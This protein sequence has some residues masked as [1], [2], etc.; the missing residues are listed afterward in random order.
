MILESPSL[1]QPLYHRGCSSCHGT[2][3]GEGAGNVG[4]ERNIQKSCDLGP[5]DSPV[6]AQHLLLPSPQPHCSLWLRHAGSSDM[7]GTQTCWSL[8]NRPER[9]GRSVWLPSQDE[10]KGFG[11]WSRYLG[12]LPCPKGTGLGG[13]HRE[14]HS[15]LSQ[16]GKKGARSF[17]R[18]GLETE[19]P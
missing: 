18:R 16:K 14:S 11:L 10:I 4:Q 3:A 12:K 15:S 19:E 17:E 1:L 9:R 13:Q 2:E 8:W 5:G 7:P 6:S